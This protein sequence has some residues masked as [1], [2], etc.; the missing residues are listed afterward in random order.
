MANSK[1]A[2]KYILVSRKKQDR[3][4]Q[5]K[6]R[7]K[8]T[9]KFAYASIENKDDSTEK[10]IAS[11]CRLIDKIASKGIIKKNTAARKKSRIMKAYNKASLAVNE[12]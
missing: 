10:N 11:T 8:S 7:L 3:N 6:T 9:V 5:F 12:K 1:S 4:K 2:K